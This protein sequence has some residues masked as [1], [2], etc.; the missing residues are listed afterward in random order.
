MSSP[1]G[2][3]QAPLDSSPKKVSQQSLVGVG[4]HPYDAKTS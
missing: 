1:K 2:D 4:S 3:I